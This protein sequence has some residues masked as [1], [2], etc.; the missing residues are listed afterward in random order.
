MSGTFEY[1]AEVVHAREAARKAD[2]ETRD[3]LVRALRRIHDSTGLED[4][5][6]PT[7]LGYIRT[8]ARAALDAAAGHIQNTE[9]QA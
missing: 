3:L 8:E 6:K 2:A 4:E 9:E 1:P 7:A 5:G